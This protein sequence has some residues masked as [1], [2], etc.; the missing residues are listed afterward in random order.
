MGITTRG[1]KTRVLEYDKNDDLVSKEESHKRIHL[2][3]LALTF[4]LNI[5]FT[6]CISITFIIPD[7]II[8]VIEDKQ[9]PLLS[10]YLLSTSHTNEIFLNPVTIY[11]NSTFKIKSTL[12]GKPLINLSKFNY[13]FAYVDNQ[14][15]Y[16][17]YGNIDKTYGLFK[18]AFEKTY[19]SKKFSTNY[20]LDNLPSFVQ[21]GSRIWLYGKLT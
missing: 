9:V 8:Y 3:L 1:G 14:E 4:F 10:P 18:S 12:E 15:L 21:V 17:L 2:L 16:I 13:N 7:T 11:K 6:I 19:S 5:T 20:K